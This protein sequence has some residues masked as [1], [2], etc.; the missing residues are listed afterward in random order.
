MVAGARPSRLAQLRHRHGCAVG[1]A[2]HRI[3]FR[4]RG[5]AGAYIARRRHY[6]SRAGH[7]WMGGNRHRTFA[8]AAHQLSLAGLSSRLQ[9]YARWHHLPRGGFRADPRRHQH[10]QQFA[11]PDPGLPP[12]RNFGFRHSFP[13]R[14]HRSRIEVRLARAHLRRTAGGGRDRAAQRKADV[15]VLFAA[16]DRQ[17]EKQ[18]NSRGDPHP[19]GFLSLHRAIERG[20][21]EG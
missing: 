8:R 17:L 19:P 20:S 6:R 4:R 14:A 9:A 16:R 12:R 11:F 7:G 5:S 21:P 3:V 18:K 2:R 15:A 13:H 1:R 10:R